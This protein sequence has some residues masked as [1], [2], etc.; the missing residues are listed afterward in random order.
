MRVLHIG[1]YYPPVAGGVE[2]LLADLG[3]AL[4]RRGVRV[5]ALVHQNSRGLAGRR[6]APDEW[7][8]V[9]RAP[10]FGQ[11]LYAP[12]SPGFP[13]WLNRVIK[14]FKP[15]LLHLHVPNTSVFAALAIPRARRLP[16]VIHWHADVGGMPLD[17]RLALAYRLYRPLEQRLLRRSRAVIA[18]SEPY[19]QASEA[20]RPWRERCVA[21]PLGL[22]TRRLTRPDEAACARAARLWGGDGLRVL[23]VGRL[24]Y[25]KGHDVLIDALTRVPEA[26]LV[27]AGSGEGQARLR[28]QIARLGLEQRVTLTGFVPDDQLSAL[29]ASC[30]LLCL[31]S[32][33]RTE[34]FGL[35][36]LEAMFFG[37]PVVVS[38]IPGSGTGWVVRQARNGVLTTP[39]DAVSVAEAIA[40]LHASP[41]QRWDL[42]EAGRTALSKLFDIDQTAVQV[43]ALYARVL[44][45]QAGNP[46]IGAG[47][48]TGTGDVA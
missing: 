6:P 8:A 39:G 29:M 4:E 18:T 42:G 35:V 48:G 20:L 43:E 17:R 15:D 21:I 28:A 12:L 19:L 11:F 27:I 9:F 5:A 33:E 32:L 41:E 30:D 3:E 23:A 14:E 26:R 38:D 16:W 10:T 34:A 22:D 44:S 25:Y 1:K 2:R 47:I 36:L 46:G 45:A 24:T 7:P 13:L 40:R 31:P 37:K